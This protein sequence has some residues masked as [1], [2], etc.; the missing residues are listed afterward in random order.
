MAKSTLYSQV[1]ASV[2]LLLMTSCIGTGASAAIPPSEF[3]VKSMVA[4]RAG[5]KGLK[6]RSV[7]KDPASGESVL[8]ITA[9][10]FSTGVVRTRFHSQSGT[11][12]PAPKEA[13][14]AHKATINESKDLPTAF[15]PTILFSP[16]FGKVENNLILAGVPIRTEDYLLSLEDEL[17]RQQAEISSMKRIQGRPQ[18]VFGLVQPTKDQRALKT[19][20]ELWVE[21]DRFIPTQLVSPQQNLNFDFRFESYS[22]AKDFPYPRRLQVW[23]RE[24]EQLL[25]TEEVIEFSLLTQE[26]QELGLSAI[27]QVGEQE[28]AAI[29]DEGAR[30][31]VR[32]YVRKMR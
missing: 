28:L 15:L 26:P 22:Y 11:Q 13:W 7:I 30:A 5:P 16:E 3:V 27:T 19:P 6:I 32:E 14:L 12:E 24:K 29:E 21:K 1:R 2:L 4:K 18:W 8:V 10:S 25:L 31:L 20:A 23:D 17:A 9:I